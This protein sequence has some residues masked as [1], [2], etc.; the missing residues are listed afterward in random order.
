VVL[1]QKVAQSEDAEET[2][3]S[4][5]LGNLSTLRTKAADASSSEVASKAQVQE[6]AEEAVMQERANASR[7]IN[8]DVT[9][10]YSVEARL[11]N[12]LADKCMER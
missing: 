12:G 9:D 6:D 4:S 7:K 2:S 5:L 1:D 10:F 11:D 3:A 8:A